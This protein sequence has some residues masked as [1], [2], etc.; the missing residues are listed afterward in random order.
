MMKLYVGNLKLSG[1]R[2]NSKSCGTSQEPF[3][4]IVKPEATERSSLFKTDS[5]I[6]IL[7]QGVT[8]ELGYFSAQRVQSWQALCSDFALPLGL[9][10]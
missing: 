5:Y 2:P 9:R 3:S 1:T 7:L 8:W 10:L 6:T 4:D